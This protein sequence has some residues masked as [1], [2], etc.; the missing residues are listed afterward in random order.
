M[1]SLV[2]LFGK[3]FYP[4]S[5]P[6]IDLPP[7]IFPDGNRP[8][9]LFQLGMGD[10][11]FHPMPEILPVK[12]VIN[13]PQGPLSLVGRMNAHQEHMDRVVLSHRPDQMQESPW[14]QMSLRLL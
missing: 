9:I 12:L 1:A 10:R 3:L 13:H 6:D 8:Q 7:E 11:L 5:S 4:A 2:I 14:E